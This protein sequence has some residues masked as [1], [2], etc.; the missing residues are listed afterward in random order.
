MSP[1]NNS[2]RSRESRC[3]SSSPYACLEARDE[4]TPN[5]LHSAF[6][7]SG[8]CGSRPNLSSKTISRSTSPPCLVATL[9]L[10]MTTRPRTFR[11]GGRR[12]RPR[13]R[14]RTSSSTRT[15]RPESTSCTTAAS[16]EKVSRRVGPATFG[17][18]TATDLGRRDARAQIVVIDEGV[19]YTHPILGGCFG[20]GCQISFGYD[21]AGDAFNGYNTPR[22]DADPCECDRDRFSFKD[23]GI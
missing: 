9:L 6:G 15:K 16:W 17:E 1:W 18:K 19:D 12:S 14:T 22:P 10:L 2:P 21:F 11:S 3:A 20:S 23:S 7:P 4:L 13:P 8:R 5:V